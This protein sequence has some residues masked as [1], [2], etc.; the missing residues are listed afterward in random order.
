MGRW[1]DRVGGSLLLMSL[2][3]CAGPDEPRQ[4]D[5][6]NTDITFALTIEVA[7][8]Q[9]IQTAS[10]PIHVKRA[11]ARKASEWCAWTCFDKE[12][13]AF[14]GEAPVVDLPNGRSLFVLFTRTPDEQGPQNWLAHTAA[15]KEEVERNPPATRV[16]RSSASRDL[17]DDGLADLPMSSPI[18]YLVTFSDNRD[19]ETITAVDPRDLAATFGKGYR[20]R[21]LELTPLNGQRLQPAGRVQKLLPWVRSF[22]IEGIRANDGSMAFPNDIARYSFIQEG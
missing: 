9:G 11:L 22:R 16:T 6:Q 10:S 4:P 5:F 21:R 13:T 20:L 19:P 15:I 3:G 12:E 18:P 1:S 7:T 8:P 14:S 2:I 17:D